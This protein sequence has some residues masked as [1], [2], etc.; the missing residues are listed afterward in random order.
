MMKK[1]FVTACFLTAV[2]FVYAITA[3]WKINERLV[4]ITFE[5]PAEGTKG[6]LSG[7]E[8][9]L[10]FNPEDLRGS[11]ITASVNVSTIN[12]GNG[13]RDEH[14]KSADFFEEAKYPRITFRSDSIISDSSGYKSY[15]QLSIKNSTQPAVIP[16]NFEKSDSGY[17][18]SGTIEVFAGDFG[19]MSK[20]L[21]GTDKVVVKIIVPV[22]K[23]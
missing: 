13:M 18:F 21:N 14:L 20:S 8:A 4:S 19:V 12:T 3:K 1:I 16:F 2:L 15:G 9:S 23:D 11:S 7:L 10:D 17:V 22:T 6:T 5:L